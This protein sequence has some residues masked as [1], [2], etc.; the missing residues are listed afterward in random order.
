MRIYAVAD[1]QCSKGKKE[2]KEQAGHDM[3]DLD[4]AGLLDGV[5]EPGLVGDLQ[6]PERGDDHVGALH[7]AHQAGLVVQVA[8]EERHAGV[9]EALE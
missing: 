5:D 2:V 7:R 4:V 8:L 9:L 3:T 6:R 1:L